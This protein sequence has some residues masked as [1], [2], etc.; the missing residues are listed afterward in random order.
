[1]LLCRPILLIV[2]RTG[3]CV[4]ACFSLVARKFC[5]FGYPRS[6]GVRVVIKSAVIRFPIWLPPRHHAYSE[7]I[8]EHPDYFLPHYIDG[9]RCETNGSLVK[10]RWGWLDISMLS[11]PPLVWAMWCIAI[12]P[13]WLI[14]LIVSFR[15]SRQGRKAFLGSGFCINGLM[16]RIVW[17]EVLLGQVRIQVTILLKKLMRGLSG[18]VPGP[19]VII[20]GP[21]VVVCGRFDWVV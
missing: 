6:L 10:H 4:R 17:W 13:I 19:P 20:C 14:G 16:H 15:P 12:Y 3:L 9:S 1:M 8:S 21:S 5:E 7:L 2:L 18:H 11:F